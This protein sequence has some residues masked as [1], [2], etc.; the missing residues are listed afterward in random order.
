MT[1]TVLEPITYVYIN[2]TYYFNRKKCNLQLLLGNEA[3][4]L[5][6][7]ILHILMYDDSEL[8]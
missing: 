4:C 6:Y 7:I 3:R 5:L 1:F 2:P 8:Q